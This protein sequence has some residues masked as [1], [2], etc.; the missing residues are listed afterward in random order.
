MEHPDVHEVIFSDQAGR[1]HARRWTNR[2]SGL[3][4]VQNSTTAALIVAEAVH[5]SAS[6][7]VRQLCAALAGELDAA[8]S[9]VPT[10]AILSPSSPRFTFGQM[11]GATMPGSV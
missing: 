3:S 10:A 2:Q 8:W 7:D 11:T 4:A 1:A 5:G 9:V 6:A